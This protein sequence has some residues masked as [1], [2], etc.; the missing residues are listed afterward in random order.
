MPCR[1]AED[2]ACALPAGEVPRGSGGSERS[3]NHRE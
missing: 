1:C 2:D 3:D